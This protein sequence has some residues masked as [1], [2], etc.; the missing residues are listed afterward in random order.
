MTKILFHVLT[1]QRKLS[2]LSESAWNML[3]IDS[4]QLTENVP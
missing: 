1:Y 4:L 2:L 3:Q